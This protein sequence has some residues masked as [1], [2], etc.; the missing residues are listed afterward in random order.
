[1]AAHAKSSSRIAAVTNWIAASVAAIMV[2]AIGC[3][4]GYQAQDSFGAPPMW[5]AFGGNTDPGDGNG[6]GGFASELVRL[7]WTSA[8]RVFQVQYP[9]DVGHMEQSTQAA[10][11][12]G[13]DAIKK[14]CNQGCIVAGFSQGTDPAVRVAA[15]NGI[16]ANNVYLFGGPM[17]STGIWHSPAV[18]HPLVEFWLNTFGFPTNTVPAA[19]S[20]FYYNSRDPYANAAP[21]CYGPGL[22]ALDV[23]QHVVV[24]PDWPTKNWV[25]SDGVDMHEF[26]YVAAPGLPL[27]GSDPSPLWAGCP[28]EGFMK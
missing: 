10:M 19:G 27:S 13:A 2:F 5:I 12:P 16:Q 23:G 11:G 25:G 15:A 26:G 28:P 14:F 24:G 9:A 3:V 20:H 4:A 21:Q 17:V 1:M 8:D 18:D 22:Y 7:G 6:G